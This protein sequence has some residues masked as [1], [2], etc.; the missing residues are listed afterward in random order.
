[1]AQQRA[2]MTTVR[3]LFANC[4]E[5]QIYLWEI[6]AFA[7]FSKGWGGHIHQ[8]S[9]YE[10][11]TACNVHRVALGLSVLYDA[12]DHWRYDA[13]YDLTATGGAGKID[14]AWGSDLGSDVFL[15]I[16]L[17]GPYIGA[18]QADRGRRR[19]HS[20][21]LGTLRTDTITGLS[22]GSYAVWAR[23]MCHQHG[24]FS[25]W[26]LPPAEPFYQYSVPIATV[27]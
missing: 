10:L 22:P 19:R 23:W 21:R 9:A 11:F 16:W 3:K 24:D 12:P 25:D 26:P 7:Y 4:T 15:E 2:I 17:E 14:L 8:W 18:R 5:D 6:D 20:E 27:T 13:I 1:M